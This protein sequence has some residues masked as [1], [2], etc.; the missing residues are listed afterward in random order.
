MYGLGMELRM[1]VAEAV[2]AARKERSWRQKDVLDTARRYGAE[3]SDNAVSEIESGRRRAD[4]ADDLAVLCLVFGVGLEKLLGAREFGLA[5]QRATAKD[6]IE[7]FEGTSERAP[8]VEL[9]GTF[10]SGAE[11]PVEVRRMA[12]KLGV[13]V[14]ELRVLVMAVYGEGSF[15][16]STR[17]ELAKVDQSDTSR[18]A[19]AKRGHATR[20][21]IKEITEAIEREGADAVMQRGNAHVEAWNK[22]IKSQLD[23]L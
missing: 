5:G 12:D 19:Q 10:Q 9:P 22:D 23:N 13:T 11:S 14:D 15:P 6:L 3:W 16:L 8:E 4:T 17:D 1:Q 2:K 21:L 7:A 20:Q 18:T